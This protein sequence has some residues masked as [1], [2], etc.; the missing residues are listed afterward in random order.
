MHNLKCTKKKKLLE[1][2]QQED[3][4]IRKL[5]KLL[6]IKNKSKLSQNF[7]DDG[8]GDLLDFCD[9]NKRDAIAQEEAN[10]WTEK[11]PEL[12]T[13][14]DFLLSKRAQKVK[15]ANKRLSE[16][17]DDENQSMGDDGAEN[18][19][20]EDFDED[21]ENGDDEMDNE[22][23]GDDD[24]SEL[25]DKKG[26]KR[27]KVESGSDSDE[28]NEDES[29]ENSFEEDEDE[30]EN[31]EDDDD[32]DDEEDDEERFIS[33]EEEEEDKKRVRELAKKGLFLWCYFRMFKKY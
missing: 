12:L 26:A 30:D 32:E 18:M 7:Y 1:D 8:L 28:E 16:E 6:K 5:E 13:A 10:A 3:K 15:E 29:E 21:M 23:F 14:N 19:D 17:T 27:R 24:M 31:G 20:E 25:G 9:E 4:E 11:A 22:S 2:N 33:K